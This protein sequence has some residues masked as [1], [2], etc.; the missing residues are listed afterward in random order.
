M[1]SVRVK[2]A[3]WSSNEKFTSA[4][5]TQLDINAANAL[6]KTVAGD[7][8]FG[9]IAMQSTARID[10]SAVGATIS[11]SI[12]AAF[13]GNA[14][15]SIVSGTPGAI[16]LAGG[17]T[18][19]PTYESATGLSQPRSFT[20][21]APLTALSVAAGWAVGGGTPLVFVG[22]ATTTTQQFALP[23]L[24]QGA[25]LSTVSCV[26]TVSSHSVV[27][28]NLPTISVFRVSLTNAGVPVVAKLASSDPQAF[29]P[30]PGSGSAWFAAGFN[31]SLTYT[32]NQN[33]VIDNTKYTYYVNVVDEN[34]SGSVSGNSYY[35]FMLGYTAVTDMR[36]Q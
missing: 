4:Q 35:A 8:L 26:L 11:A 32:T 30:T 12:Y 20:R 33:N 22:P 15:A 10:M 36:P 6:D 13:V 5:A 2:G 21:T 17:A 19:Y 34:G 25:T 23:S 31:Q 9:F 18:D 3:G 14:V 7:S 27:P 24:W 29:T 1:S 16:A 28:V